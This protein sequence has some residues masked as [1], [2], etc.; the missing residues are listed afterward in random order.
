MGSQAQVLGGASSFA[1]RLAP[2][3]RQ[4]GRA[5]RKNPIMVAGIVLMLAMVIIG[6]I[7]PLITSRGPTDID[8]F[9]RLE[10]PSSAN[11]FGTDSIGRDVFSR[12]MYGARVSLGVG[13]AVAAST[14]LAGVVVG[15]VAGYY[16]RADM[17]IMRVM[18]AMLA[19]PFLLLAI[20]L[21]AI[22]GASIKNVI[23][24][25]L[26]VMTPSTARVVRS[27][28]LSLREE[29]YVDAAR[30]I[31]APDWRVI[32]RHILPGT[33]AP[34]IIQ[35]TYTMA[36]AI[37]VEASLSFLGA[38]SPP[39]TPSWGVIMADGRAFVRVAIWMI[40]F[41]GIFLFITILGI[42]LAGDG[43]RDIL[44]PKLQRRD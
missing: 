33:I 26:I 13:F 32:F 23:I 19:I 15:L 36:I 24:S 11:W 30:A 31:G 2:A 22:L 25:L 10:S 43:L 44:D 34:L 5:S 21:M 14:M 35:G 4:V 41:P 8:A 7:A 38:G 1:D 37:L 27:S 17:I 39:T 29:V 9:Q 16:R 18:D 3:M 42:N 6:L 20:A 12:T 40:M 28:V